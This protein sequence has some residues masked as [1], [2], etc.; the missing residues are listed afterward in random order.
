MKDPPTVAGLLVS[1][2]RQRVRGLTTRS[3]RHSTVVND[4]ERVSRCS[5]RGSSQRRPNNRANLNTNREER[6]EKC[7][8][9]THTQFN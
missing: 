9:Q 4:A 7:E 6:T 2:D 1:D 5:R 8:R 3:D